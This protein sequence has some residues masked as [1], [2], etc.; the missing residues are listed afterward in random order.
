MKL[1]ENIRKTKYKINPL[2]L[3]RWSPRAMSGELL[4]EE[5]LMSL[6]EAARWAPSSMNNQLW[7]FI[8]VKKDSEYWNNFFDLLVEGNKTWCKNAS[9]LIILISRKNNYHNNE[10]QI[11]HS[12]E[13]GMAFENLALEGANKN[14]VVHGMAGFDYDKAK[15]LLKLENNWQVECIIAVGKKANKDILPKELQ[16]K[17]KPSER[18][19][20]NQIAIEFKGKFED[21]NPYK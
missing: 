12:L 9:A 2:I 18:L 1:K 11:T 6:F 16:D 4:K 20:I 7:R 17:E 15:E 3:N 19:D 8:Y 13:A 21:I 14:I 10:I 5:E